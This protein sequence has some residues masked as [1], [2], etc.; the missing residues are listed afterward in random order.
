MNPFV[1]SSHRPWHHERAEDQRHQHDISRDSLC[2]PSH[3]C[4][5]ASVGDVVDQH[6]EERPECHGEKETS[7]HQVR[8]PDAPL[9]IETM[10]RAVMNCGS[11]GLAVRGSMPIVCSRLSMA[12]GGYLLLGLLA[13]SGA[14]GLESPIQGSEQNRAND[15]YH[16]HHRSKRNQ[17]AGETSESAVLGAEIDG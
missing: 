5:P 15:A 14:I 17:F 7:A 1:E 8:V 10:G 4:T 11:I 9:C 6:E 3:H 12:I 13:L 2:Q 16:R